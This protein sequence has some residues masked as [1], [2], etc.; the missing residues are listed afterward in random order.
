VEGELRKKYL[1]ELTKEERFQ[2]KEVISKGKT[3]A[4]KI[5]HANI[6]LAADVNGPAWPDADIAQAL[7]ININTI[8]RVRQRFFEQG[9]IAAVERKRQENPSRAAKFDGLAEA[10]LLAVSCSP[11]PE[12]CSRWTLRLLADKAV[13]LEIVDSVVPETV[14]QTLKK[15]RSSL[16]LR[17]DM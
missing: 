10:H 12:G 5:Q 6:L 1:V 4:Y 14:R 2:L 15:M 11:P 3:A 13:E 16:I 7:D 8:G 17:K 9:L